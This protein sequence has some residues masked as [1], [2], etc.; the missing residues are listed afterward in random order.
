MWR[1]RRIIAQNLCA[2]RELDYYLSQGVTT[3]VFGN[4]HDNESQRS[5][6]SGKSALLEAIAVG[7]TGS[8][9]R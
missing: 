5:N 3:L 6:G 1:L 4:N 7:I 8:P 2:F 9:M